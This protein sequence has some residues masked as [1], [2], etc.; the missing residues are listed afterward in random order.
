MNIPHKF[1]LFILMFFL[2]SC[3]TLE[4]KND[5]KKVKKYYTSKGFALIYEESFFKDGIVNKRLNNEVLSLLHSSLKRNTPIKIVN[6]ENSKS[7]FTKVSNK[8]KYPIIFNSV[9][10][11]EVARVLELNPENPY[12][13]IFEVKKNKTFVAKEGNIFEEEINVAEKAPVSKIEVDDLSKSDSKEVVELKNNTIF[14]LVISDFYYIDSANYLKNELINKYKFENL[15][16]SKISDN[17]YRLL[18]GPFKNFNSLK[19]TII[20]LNDF[21]FEDLNIIK[22]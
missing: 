20:S 1:L 12:I 22:K 5:T 17:K 2:S 7:I 14:F 8:A 10:T 16:V 4:V 11:N 9:I 15:N 18:A 13:E 21:G 6:P 19:F 3:T